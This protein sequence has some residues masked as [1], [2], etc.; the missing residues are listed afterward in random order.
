MLLKDYVEHIGDAGAAALFGV[1]VRTAMS[2]R[3]GER[4]PRHEKA[5]DIVRLTKG[6]VSYSECYGVK[7]A[8][9]T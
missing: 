9:S 5:L 4:I 6:R 1:K 2:W 8:V 7:P 3:L